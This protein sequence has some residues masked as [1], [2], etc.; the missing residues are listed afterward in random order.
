MKILLFGPNGQVGWELQRALAPLGE[1]V[2]LD[3]QGRDG[4]SGDLTDPDALRDTIMLFGL[5][6]VVVPDVAGS[7][8]GH[9]ADEWSG[10]S[11]GGA[12]VDDLRGLAGCGHVLAVGGH[13]R[14]PAERLA[15]LTG[16]EPV[17][18]P[19]ATGLVAADNLI[20]ALTAMSGRP[21]PGRLRRDRA[22]LLDAM[23]DGQFFYGGKRLV[24]CAEPDLLGALVALLDEMGAAVDAVTTVRTPGLDG[25]PAGRVVVGDLSDAE[26]LAG[27]GADALV[28]PSHLRHAAERYHLPLFRTGFPQFDRLGAQ[29]QCALGHAGTRAVVNALGNLLMEAEL[30]HGDGPVPPL[31]REEDHA[32]APAAAG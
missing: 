26:A 12:S 24:A 14:G 7:L 16:I 3:R 10:A 31:A 13:M 4:L 17:L 9:V 20:A 1:V 8:D 11:L 27:E 6:P 2:A 23:M 28:G 15:A 18:L 29:D 22:R 21:A 5:E 30:A 32:P 25:L 19:H